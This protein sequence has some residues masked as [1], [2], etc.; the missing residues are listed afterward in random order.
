MTAYS[1]TYYV[2]LNGN[3][4]SSGQNIVQ[5]WRSL[6]KINS[7]KFLP[8]D[9]ILLS[10]KDT[11]DGSIYFPDS[12][13]GSLQKSIY[14][15][16][17]GPGK[18]VINSK[19]NT[20]FYAYNNHC[21]TLENLIFKGSG[22]QQNSGIGVCFYMDLLNNSKLY[23]IVLN[24]VE[25]YGYKTAG[26]SVSSYSSDFSR[27]GYHNIKILNCIARENGHVGIT[28]WGE[29]NT[30]D[31]LYSHSN[32]IIRNCIAY[33]NHGISGHTNHSGNGILVGQTDTC[34]IEYCEAYENGR[35]NDFPLAGPAGIW[36]WDSKFVCIQYCYSHHNRSQTKDG[37]GFDLDGG[38]R[39]SIMQYNYS[40]FNDGPGFLVAQFTGARNMKNIAIRYNISEKDGKGLGALIWSGDPGGKVTSEKIDFYN[41][42]IYVDTIADQNTNAA[43][44]VYNN[45]GAMK[46]VRICNNIFITKNRVCLTDFNKTINLKCYNNSYYDN[47]D[48]F[49]FKDQNTIYNNLTN[50]RNSTNQEIYDGKNVGFR[51]NP[52]L[53]N[54]G[55]AGSIKN[56]DSLKS[57]FQYRLNNNSPLINKGI[58]IDSLLYFGTFQFDFFGDS[59]QKNNQYS[60]GAS[61]IRQVKA[62]FTIRTTCK[63][64]EIE[65]TNTGLNGLTFLWHF[66]DGKYSSVN[67]PIHQYDSFGSFIVKLIVFGK[68]GYKD[69]IQKLI[70]VYPNPVASYSVNNFCSGDTTYFE[71]KSEFTTDRHWV[72]DNTY[73][74][75]SI[76]PKILFNSSGLKQIQL[77]ASNVNGCEDTLNQYIEIFEKP[78]ADFII[79]NTCINDTL[80]LFTSNSDMKHS[81]YYNFVKYSN[82]TVFKFTSQT[83]KTIQITLILE[84]EEACIDSISK[85]IQIHPKPLISL[86]IQDHCFKANLPILNLSTENY[87]YFWN[88]GDGNFSSDKFPEYQ[89]S[90]P[91]YYRV[92]LYVTDSIGCTDSTIRTIKVNTLPNANFTIEKTDFQYILKAKDSTYLFY[93]WDINGLPINENKS[94]ISIL[95][96]NVVGKKINLRVR[97]SFACSDS[98]SKFI[99]DSIT[100]IK[101]LYSSNSFL[102]AGPNPFSNSIEITI[103]Y[104]LPVKIC[105]YNSNGEL[106]YSFYNISRTLSISTDEYP[107][108]S[109]LYFLV[110]DFEKFHESIIISKQ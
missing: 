69:S 87:S 103:S 19:N 59:I 65:F 49:R 39:N 48:G 53:I 76:K 110:A 20:G 66:G 92:K 23:N 26:I 93:Y 25:V 67:N 24:Q 43:I 4:S 35:N 54:A 84:T 46:D 50:W 106:V 94:S 21:F 99:T 95:K 82:D 62:N 42:T 45:F 2:S 78:I 61:E 96:Q 71:D 28:I 64:S 81:W 40:C 89:Y 55:N 36:A 70:Q 6:T 91:G 18:A 86:T 107:L 27:S 41:N 8:G 29:F 56:I 16:S 100:S 90:N 37:D 68:Y 83:T 10:G 30:N 44:A 98:S 105:I 33:N 58:L 60:I 34:L 80:I 74:S 9:S 73:L 5:A 51:I 85:N 1:K 47:G 17:Y 97:D 63:N 14:L 75:N 13:S 11:F 3:D 72:I 108:T 101:S 79:K 77:I 57:I 22:L 102:S 31:T 52:M 7:S 109:G 38:V 12:I 32:I 15:G 104:P 88:F